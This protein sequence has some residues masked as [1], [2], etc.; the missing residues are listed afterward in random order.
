MII[1][2]IVQIITNHLTY[3]KNIILEDTLIGRQLP[4]W[5][6]LTLSFLF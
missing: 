4:P 3:D 2:P 1:C 6:K 5:N